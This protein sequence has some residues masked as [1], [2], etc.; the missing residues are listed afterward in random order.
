LAVELI[1]IFL[2]D[3]PPWSQNLTFP[4]TAVALSMARLRRRPLR[5][6]LNASYT[7]WSATMSLQTWL[8]SARQTLARMSRSRA[9]NESRN[10]QACLSFQERRRFGRYLFAAFSAHMRSSR[11]SPIRRPFPDVDGQRT[12]EG[13]QIHAGTERSFNAMPRSDRFVRRRCTG[14]STNVTSRVGRTMPSSR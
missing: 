3:A 7:I 5:G 1:W 6:G 10:I 13:M 11:A 14:V 12:W 9:P 4:I 2:P 8:M